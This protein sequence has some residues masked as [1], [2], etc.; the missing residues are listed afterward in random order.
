MLLNNSVAPFTG[1][2]KN[3]SDMIDV[4]NKEI[5]EIVYGNKTAQE[6]MDSAAEQ[7]KTAGIELAL[8]SAK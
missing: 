2:I 5:D 4:V 8:R 7:I 3:F 1:T 6:G